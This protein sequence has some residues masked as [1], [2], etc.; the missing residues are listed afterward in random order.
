MTRLHVLGSGSRGNCLAVEHEGAILLIDAGFSAREI[1]RR[2]ETAGLD[3][4]RVVGLALTHEHGDHARGARVLTKRLRVPVI[5][6]PGTWHRLR[7]RLNH[8]RHQPVGI[9]SLVEAGPFV[10]EACLTSHDALE[11]VAFAVRISD[12]NLLGVAYDVGRPTAA[13]RYLL[14][15]A[16]A[17]VIEANH[18]EVML[19][20]SSYPA[21]V[22]QRIAG[23]SG[24]L[25]NRAT[26]DLVA[27]L[28]HPSL[29]TVV[30]AHLSERC[31]TPV[32]ARETI[33][34][35]LRGAG[36]R[37]TLAV[38]LQDRPLPAIDLGSP[39]RKRG[40]AGAPPLVL[41]V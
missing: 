37:G 38:A 33:E 18:D 1:G 35:V 4:D 17:L 15:E 13:V 10:I 20:T 12:G 19:R 7:D 31:N 27:E 2:A 26:A 11:P 36:F 24:H 8:C 28:V 14:R 21:T 34:P 32:Q 3:L 40:G 41:D 6:S 29:G 23:S 25:S 5:S 39:P 16:T 9:T 22:R 30:L